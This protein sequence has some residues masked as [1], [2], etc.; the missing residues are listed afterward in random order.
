MA[1]PEPAQRHRPVLRDRVVEL[2]EPALTEPGSVCVD[3][4]LGIGGHAE[5]ILERCPQVRVVG[6][7]RDQQALDLAGQRLALCGPAHLG[8][9]G[10]R[11]VRR[12]GR[13]LGRGPSTPPSST[14]A[15]PRSSWTRRTAASPTASTPLDMR[16]D[17]SAGLTAAEVLNTYDVDDLT[18]ILRDYGEERFARLIARAVVQDRDAEPFSTSG[19]LV[20]LL[21]SVIPA[22]SQRSGGQLGEA[23]LPG[24]ADRGERGAGCVGDRAPGGHRRPRC[25]RPDRRPATTRWRTGSPSAPS[26]AAPARALRRDFRSSAGARRTPAA[27]DPRR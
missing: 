14:S 18:R 20:E 11:R 4:T 25:R 5:G 23:D 21:R 13:V 2:L 10:V 17:Q 12:G 19:R 24:P 15:S 26:P 8:A 16:M 27:A 7:D 1:T 6:I 22:A 9:R 3:G